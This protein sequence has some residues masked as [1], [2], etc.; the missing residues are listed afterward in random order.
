MHKRIERE[1]D[2]EREIIRTLTS[3]GW[4][5]GNSRVISFL[6]FLAALLFKGFLEATVNGFLYKLDVMLL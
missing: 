2:E 4:R 5:P 1:R 6:N 3:S